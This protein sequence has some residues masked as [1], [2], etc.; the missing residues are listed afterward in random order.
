M[1]NTW[2]E[3][4]S[5]DFPYQVIIRGSVMTTHLEEFGGSSVF[6]LEMGKNV[7][8][9]G[10]I[11]CVGNILHSPYGFSVHSLNGYV[12]IEDFKQIK[13][14]T[15]FDY[16]NTGALWEGNDLSDA[17]KRIFFLRTRNGGFAKLHVYGLQTTP[18]ACQFRYEFSPNGLFE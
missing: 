8:K 1:T 14:I 10:D 4:I 15:G 3:P 6:D 16:T 2:A 12:T 9:N 5:K 18:M 11:L 17:N 7:Y 13:D